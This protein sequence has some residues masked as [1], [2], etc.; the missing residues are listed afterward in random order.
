M[1]NPETSRCLQEFTEIFICLYLRMYYKASTKLIGPW[2][3]F[4]FIKHQY[5]FHGTSLFYI[6]KLKKQKNVLL[7]INIGRLLNFLE[8][9]KSK[10]PGPK[11]EVRTKML[12]IWFFL[13]SILCILCSS[14]LLFSL[15]LQLSCIL[16]NWKNVQKSILTL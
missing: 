9:Q 3:I 2:K 12:H 5:I 7:T 10:D 8:Y 4:F 16:F 15:I 14:F 6:T 13:F 11:K 1:D